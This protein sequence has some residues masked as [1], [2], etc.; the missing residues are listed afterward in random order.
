RNIEGIWAPTGSSPPAK[1]RLAER[2]NYFRLAVHLHNDRP[3]LLDFPFP[4][5]Y[6]AVQENLFMSSKCC[7]INC[8]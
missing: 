7:F 5:F 6:A 1:V 2:Q 4:T 8:T 3:S